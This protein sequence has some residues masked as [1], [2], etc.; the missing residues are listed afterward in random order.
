M[1]N[2]E[3]IEA[4]CKQE[5]LTINSWDEEHENGLTAKLGRFVVTTDDDEDYGLYSGDEGELEACVVGSEQYN[6]R[7]ISFSFVPD[8]LDGGTEVHYLYVLDP[9][10]R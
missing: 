10:T 2:K 3:M 5:G 8:G 1:N 9:I 7:R 6:N 4:R